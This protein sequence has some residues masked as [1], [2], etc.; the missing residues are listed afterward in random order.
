ALTIGR[1]LVHAV[2][3]ISL[4]HGFD[5]LR[6]MS[7]QVFLTESPATFGT[8]LCNSHRQISAIER[9]AA[10]ARYL[11]QGLGLVRKTK[12]LTCLWRLSITRERLRKTRLIFQA[13]D[14]RCPM[15]GH[16]R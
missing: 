13:L 1:N 3:S 11:R 4:V 12:Y 14:L 16:H 7:G 5:P 2:A 9:F 15:H 8:E 10:S 6:A